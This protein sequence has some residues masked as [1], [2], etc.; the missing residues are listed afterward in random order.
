MTRSRAGSKSA[1]RLPLPLFL[2]GGLFALEGAAATEEIATAVYS[3]ELGGSTTIAPGLFAPNEQT[4]LIEAGGEKKRGRAKRRAPGRPNPERPV[5]QRRQPQRAR[6][7]VEPATD[8]SFVCEE[9]VPFRPDTQSYRLRN[10]GSAELEWELQTSESWISVQGPRS[11]SLAPG[12]E[13]ELDLGVETLLTEDFPSGRY[14]G[15]ASIMDTGSGQVIDQRETCLVIE[16]TQLVDGWSEFTPSSDSRL[17]YVS[18]SG[19][20]DSNDGLSEAS[21]KATISAGLTLMRQGQPDWLMLKK[22]DV[23]GSADV[24]SSGYRWKTAGRSEEQPTV[25]T[26]YGPAGAGRPLIRTAGK[27]GLRM[28]GGSG[29]PTHLEH[30]AIMGL[31]FDAAPR[32]ALTQNPTGARFLV[33]TENLLVEDCKFTN[34]KTALAIQSGV[35]DHKSVRLRRNV[36]ANC[37]DGNHTHAQGT[38]L[39]DIHRL[40]IEGNVIDHGGWSEDDPDAYPPDIFKHNIYIQADCSNVVV[41]KNI[42]SNASSHGVQLRPGGVIDNNLFLRNSVSILAAASIDDPDEQ[43]FAV[44]RRNVILDAKDITPSLLRRQAMHV[45]N[46]R[47]GWISE[48]IVAN[49]V[50]HSSSK[51]ISVMA[52]NENGTYMGVKDL[53]IERNVVS[54]WGG[55]ALDIRDFSRPG[56]V[57]ERVTVRDNDFQNLQD[58]AEIIRHRSEETLIETASSNNRFYLALSQPNRWAQVEDERMSLTSYLDMVED[59]DSSAEQVSYPNAELTIETYMGALGGVPTHDAFIH[60]ALQQSKDNWRPEYT[61]AAVNEF[62]RAGFG[63]AVN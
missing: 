25:F 54:G 53:L 28:M 6:L 21:P 15:T 1:A 4:G 10:M 40:L 16:A 46:I 18:S 23:F 26:S 43:A 27:A 42:L 39:S 29:T 33:P 59:S 35:G 17:V 20:S 24:P 30:I 49:S 2:V 34:F 14:C 22:G 13:I 56:A 5:P 63:M 45:Q 12:A 48:N 19:G 9:G 61:A 38:Y 37:Y 32:D 36:L 57:F 52:L 3:A 60:E 51:G 50:S 11:G 47:R 7:S 62:M 58:D 44:I 55:P 31:E 8:C 41:R